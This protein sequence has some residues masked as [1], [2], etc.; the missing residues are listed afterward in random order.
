MAT[1]CSLCDWPQVGSND[2]TVGCN[3]Y[4]TT[5]GDRPLYTTTERAAIEICLL[6]NS[7]HDATVRVNFAIGIA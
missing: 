2:N 5:L 4:S 7:A 6:L 1:V 3:S